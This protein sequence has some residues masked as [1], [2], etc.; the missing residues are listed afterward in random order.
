MRR[1]LLLTAAV[2]AA[3]IVFVLAT[4][5]PAPVRLDLA[6]SNQDVV[7]RTVAGAYH[8]HT[9]RSDG[10]EDKASV[11]AAAARAGLRFAIFSDHGDGTRTPDA[12]A[13]IDGVLCLDGVEISTNGGHYVALDMPASPY[14]LGG[15]AAA[16]VEDV[17]RLGGFGIAAH[18]HSPKRELAWHDWRAPFDGIEWLNVDSEWRDEPRGRLAATFVRHLVRPAPAIASLFQVPRATVDRWAAAMRER[19]VVALA[20]V[21]A[22]GRMGRRMEGGVPLGPS[23]EGSFR[24]VSNR[25]LLDRPFSGDAAVDARLLM[26]AIRKGRVYSVVDALAAPAYFDFASEPLSP[27]LTAR[28]ERVGEGDRAWYLVVVGRDGERQLPWLLTNP[29]QF[30]RGAAPSPKVAAIPAEPEGGEWR[31]EHDPTS[32]GSIEKAP[33]GGLT[34]NYS[35]GGG[36]RMN[37]FVAFALDLPAVVPA[38]QIAFEGGSAKPM[39]MSVQ[40][41]VPSL[42]E[43]WTKSVYLDAGA[44][45]VV[46]AVGDMVPAENRVSRLPAAEAP[47]S[48]LLVVDLTNARPG[49]SGRVVIRGVRVINR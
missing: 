33:G 6:A 38:R 46:V 31:V 42:N 9:T 19:P 37:Q 11:A 10:A 17:A 44:R 18:P 16:V 12:P 48:L 7:R 24:T 40:L 1:L 47:G 27:P 34:L 43:R 2:L 45:E 32:R 39:R 30:E 28:V 20:A 21:D 49:D 41:R 15:E 14:P 25:V 36:T 22:H 8:I 5:P 29:A 23:Y 13:Y 26:D 35:L 3:V 4:L